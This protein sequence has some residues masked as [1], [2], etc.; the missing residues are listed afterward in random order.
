MDQFHRERA[1]RQRNSRQ[2]R[3]PRGVAGEEYLDRQIRGGTFNGREDAIRVGRL[4]ADFDL[5]RAGVFDAHLIRAP[6]IDR[7]LR[8]QAALRQFAAREL[9]ERQRIL[10]AGGNR[11]VRLAAAV[12]VCRVAVWFC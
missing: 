12:R 3:S 7:L 1:Q 6:K 8:R 2:Q 10:G 4:I 9:Q 11:H 5:L